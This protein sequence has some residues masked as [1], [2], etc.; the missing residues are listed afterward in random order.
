MGIVEQTIA[1]SFDSTRFDP[2]RFARSMDLATRHGR[3][4]VSR[5]VAQTEGSH[6]TWF[7]QRTYTTFESGVE[8]DC[9]AE[10]TNWFTLPTLQTTWKCPSSRWWLRGNAH[11]F[12]CAIP[13]VPVVERQGDL[14]SSR[15][16]RTHHDDIEYGIHVIVSDWYFACAATCIIF[17][18]TSPRTLVQ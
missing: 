18:G 8:N 14:T 7:D 1:V 12:A 17:C 2:T 6:T 13:V 10:T 3:R 11:S 15:N 9:I 16:I 4:S 5:V